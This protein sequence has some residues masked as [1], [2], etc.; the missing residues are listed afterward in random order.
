MSDPEYVFRC[1]TCDRPVKE[2]DPKINRA[3]PFCSVRCQYVDL[4]KWFDEG[5]VVPGQTIA[6]DMPL[7]GDEALDD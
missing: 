5:F 7:D 2:R 4:G 3:L 6:R 1:P